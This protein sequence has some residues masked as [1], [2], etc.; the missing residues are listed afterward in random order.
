MT[1]WP[2]GAK[3]NILHK[4]PDGSRHAGTTGHLEVTWK[5]TWT[6]DRLDGQAWQEEC[7]LPPARGGH[8]HNPIDRATTRECAAS[9][10]HPVWPVMGDQLE[11]VLLCDISGRE[12]RSEGV[13]AGG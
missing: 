3:R 4:G 2:A 13:H 10:D 5:R 1:C 6:R 7:R 11:A 8:I 9:A 12:R